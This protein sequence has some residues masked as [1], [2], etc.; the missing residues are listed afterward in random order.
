LA[1]FLFVFNCGNGYSR[2]EVLHIYRHYAVQIG[3]K[4]NRN[5]SL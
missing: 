3:N 5:R 4:S 2:M 1:I